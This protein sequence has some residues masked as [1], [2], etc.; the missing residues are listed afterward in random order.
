MFYSHNSDMAWVLKKMRHFLISLAF[1]LLAFGEAAADIKSADSLKSS[2]LAADSSLLYTQDTITLQSKDSLAGT[3]NTE[4]KEI[5]PGRL[6]LTIGLGGSFY[7]GSYFLILE[8]GWWSETGNDFHFANDFDY[9]KNL[10]KFGHAYSGI[11]MGEFFGGMFRWSGFSEG[12][13]YA[14]GG[15]MAFVSHVGIDIKDGY[16]PQWGF[17][18]WDVIAGTIGGFWP[19]L[20]R[21]TPMGEYFDIKLGYWKNSTVYWDKEG[22]TAGGGIFTDDYTNQVH[23]LTWKVNKSLPKRVEPYWPDFL[24]LGV[25]LSIDEGAFVRGQ[26]ALY[27]IYVG[28]DWDLDVWLEGTWA[29]YLNYIRL[30]IPTVQVY[31]H[32]RW[33]LAYPIIIG[34]Y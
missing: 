20:Q 12:S 14:L 25:G 10:D 4:S 16:A 21:T 1:A 17:S 7:L 18:V 33:H 31:P 23:W 32:L 8:K 26:E 30:P 5:L 24:A 11:L 13:A 19:W 29:E 22:H 6:A 28:P 34:D 3:K 27:E 15:A 9:A 2:Q